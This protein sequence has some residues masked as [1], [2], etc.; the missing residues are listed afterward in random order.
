MYRNSQMRRLGQDDSGLTLPSLDSVAAPVSIS[1]SPLLLGGIGLL[2]VAI[3]LSSTKKA[4]VAV[5]RK[6]R[7][8]RRALRA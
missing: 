5:T 1:V 3:L 6:G 8:V 4:V 2:G 7:A